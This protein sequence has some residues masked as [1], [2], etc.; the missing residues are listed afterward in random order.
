MITLVRSL[1]G[2]EITEGMRHHHS[3][4]VTWNQKGKVF[5][6]SEDNALP[7]IYDHFPW[8]E[9]DMNPSVHRVIVNMLRSVQNIWNAIE[10]MIETG[11][12]PE[13]IVISQEAC[14]DTIRV[15]AHT[16][17]NNLDHSQI[18]SDDFPSLGLYYPYIFMV[19]FWH[20]QVPEG[21]LREYCRLQDL[22]QLTENLRYG[23]MEYFTEQLKEHLAE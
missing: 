14:V 21:K 13:V 3:W 1:Y 8:C 16:I 6:E 10:G 20:N 9:L 4:N 5:G 11:E 18:D 2:P 17:A 7:D 19:K 12:D 23:D 22:E 15:V